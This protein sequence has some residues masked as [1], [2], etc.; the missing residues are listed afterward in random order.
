MFPREGDARWTALRLFGLGEGIFDSADLRVVELRR[1]EGERSSAAI[2]RYQQAVLRGL[3]RLEDESAHFEGFHIG[4]ISIAGVL[5]WIDWLRE[6][7]GN[8]EEWR[9]GRPTL[10][11]WYAAFVERPSYQRR[12]E[13]HPAE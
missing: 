6:T 3:D 11:A 12:Q 10:A 5:M 8:Q 9:L 2:D 7:R 4:L 13:L 1:S